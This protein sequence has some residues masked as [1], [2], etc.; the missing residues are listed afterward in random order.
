MTAH[1]VICT[2]NRGYEASLE[3]RKLYEVLPDRDAEKHGQL[4]IV[5]ESGEDYLYPKSYFVTVKLPQ[6][7]V[8]RV[9]LARRSTG[10]ARTTARAG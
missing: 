9:R 4:R 6:Q 3:P 2:E 1:L 10:R 8:R 5:D 7:V